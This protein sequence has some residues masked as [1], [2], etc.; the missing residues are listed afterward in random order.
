[1]EILRDVLLILH[2]IGLASLLGG[3]LVQMK[4][5]TKVINA[6]MLHGVLTQVVTGVA[7]V[8]LAEA[9]DAD[10]DHTKVGLK[11]AVTIAI[12]VLVIMFRKRDA[13]TPAVW[14]AIGALTL[15]NIVVAVVW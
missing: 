4:P 11:L 12:A 1:M 5:R 10:L 14:G 8:G 7:L 9:N 6:A 2:F 3:F 13:V 15:V